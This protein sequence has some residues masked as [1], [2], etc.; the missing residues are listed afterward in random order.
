M[1][2]NSIRIG[3]VS[4]RLAGTDGVSLESA[5]WCHVLHD[6]GHTCY[7]FAGECDRPAERSR[8]VAEAHFSHP[9]VA[10]TTQNLFDN[11]T[12]RVPKTTEA[13][14]EMRIHLKRE[15]YSFVEDF[16][17]QL[18]KVENALSMPMNVPLGLALTELVTETNIPTIAHHHD[19]YWERDRFSVNA[20]TDFLHA[21]FPPAIPSICHVVINSYAATEL[22]RRTGMRSFRIPN[23][24]DF[25]HDPDLGAGPRYQV[26]KAL[27]LADDETFLLQPTRVV[28]RKCIERSIE[29]ARWLDRPAKLVVSHSSGDEGDQ[30]ARYLSRLAESLDVPLIFGDKFFSYEAGVNEEGRSYFSLADAYLSSDFVTYPS[31]VEGFG[32]AFLEAIYFRRPLMIGGY[33]IFRTDIEPKGFRVIQMEGFVTEQTLSEVQ[34]V[35]SNPGLVEEITSHNFELG[36]KHY[37]LHVLRDRVSAILS[38]RFPEL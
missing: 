19:F 17:I 10:R 11:N 26:R 21:A 12:H 33:D 18:L 8:L 32:N 22:A 5:K 36:R 25:D 2:Q 34:E 13:I 15:L 1:N 35:L 4:T 14:H 3:I 24:M 31:L 16:G 27:D 37:S 30:Y 20:A 38:Q 7:Y 29:L 6:L 9:E 23:V 28:P